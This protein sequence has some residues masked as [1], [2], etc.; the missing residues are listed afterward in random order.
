MHNSLFGV[1]RSVACH[2]VNGPPPKTDPPDRKRQEAT[3]RLLF[4][5]FFKKKEATCRNRSPV[6]VR[7][8]CTIST[9]KTQIN[10][11]GGTLTVQEKN[12]GL[13]NDIQA[14]LQLERDDN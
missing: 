9:L 2:D 4:G 1:Y 11:L 6:A 3:W 5:T 13:H 12:L 7:Y 14:Y 10:K 8:P